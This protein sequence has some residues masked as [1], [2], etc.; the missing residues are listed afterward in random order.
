MSIKYSFKSVL[1]GF[2]ICKSFICNLEYVKIRFTGNKTETTEL[3]MFKDNGRRAP[4]WCAGVFCAP[5]L[6]E[7][8]LNHYTLLRC[9][10]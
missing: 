6:S 2:E 4:A 3:N 1:T 10:V 7:G 9:H 8:K 5:P